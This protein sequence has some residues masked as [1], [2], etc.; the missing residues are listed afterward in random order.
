MGEAETADEATPTAPRDI[1]T[2]AFFEEE[3]VR[4]HMIVGGNPINPAT[5]VTINK[6]DAPLVIHAWKTH[7]TDLPNPLQDSSIALQLEPG[8]RIFS[9][10]YTIFRPAGLDIGGTATEEVPVAIFA[11]PGARFSR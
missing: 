9:S 7:R 3:R 11:G 2:D 10:Q 4:A 5:G 8:G 6:Y 1:G